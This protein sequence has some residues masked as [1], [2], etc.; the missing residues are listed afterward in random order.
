MRTPSSDAPTGR[1]PCSRAR[2]RGDGLS[3]P[4]KLLDARLYVSNGAAHLAPTVPRRAS[5]TWGGREANRLI[6][7]LRELRQAIRPTRVHRSS[8]TSAPPGALSFAASMNL[9]ARLDPAAIVRSARALLCCG[10]LPSHVRYP[11]HDSQAKQE[12]RLAGCTIRCGEVF[13][14]TDRELALSALEQNVAEVAS[15]NAVARTTI[16]SPHT[17]GR[18]K[19]RA[20]VAFAAG[21]AST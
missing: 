8:M 16:T 18:M 13:E 14:V 9:R 19:R 17:H 2:L 20:K 15:R 10:Q 7:T 3:C 1:L 4:L 6:R 5:A 21:C 11:S 12:L